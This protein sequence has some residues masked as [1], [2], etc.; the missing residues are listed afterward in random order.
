MLWIIKVWIYDLT[1]EIVLLCAYVQ[2][3]QLSSV[4]TVPAFVPNVE[5][6][7]RADVRKVKILL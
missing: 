2:Y 4:R 6:G 1:I 3:T 5:F 7:E